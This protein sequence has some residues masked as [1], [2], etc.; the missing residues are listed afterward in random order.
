MSLAWTAIGNATPS[1]ETTGAAIAW[2]LL[3]LALTPAHST[4]AN[5]HPEVL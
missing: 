3:M 1:W 2:T 5:A 4:S